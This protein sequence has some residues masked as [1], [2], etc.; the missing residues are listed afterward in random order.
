MTYFA[1]YSYLKAQNP[2]GANGYTN[3]RVMQKGL[4]YNETYSPVARFTSIRLL[5]SLSARLGF[6]VH[7]MDVETAFLK[8]ELKEDRYVH[9]PPV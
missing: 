6:D 2:S 3:A 4:D 8:A 5:L 1:I 7:Q 9:P